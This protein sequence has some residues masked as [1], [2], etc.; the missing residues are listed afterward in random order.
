M[1]SLALLGEL[2]QELAS[3]GC[4]GEKRVELRIGRGEFR[5][6]LVERIRLAGVVDA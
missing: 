1:A 2:A 6:H 3:T 5:D 4:L